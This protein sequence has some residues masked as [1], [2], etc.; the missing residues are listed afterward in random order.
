[1]IKDIKNDD[2]WHIMIGSAEIVRSIADYY[3]KM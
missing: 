3:N 2:I 1:M